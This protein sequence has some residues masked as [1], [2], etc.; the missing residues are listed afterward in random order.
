MHFGW[1]G[2]LLLALGPGAGDGPDADAAVARAREALRARLGIADSRINLVDASAAR[3]NDT[4]LGCPEKGQVYQPVLTQGHVVHLRVDDRT[5]DLRVTG[6]R[7][8]VCE[9]A[10]GAAAQAVA[11]ARVS[12]LARR[13]LA[14]R[15]K[16]SESDVHVEFVRPR[17]W[18]DA[19]LGCGAEGSLAAPADDGVRGFLIELTAGGQRHEY[20]ADTDRVVACG[21]GT[22]RAPKP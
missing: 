3:W 9:A 4:S 1:L 2:A 22:T 6:E 10:D 14:A 17:T 16:L 20:H 12:R 7:A 15:L 5:Y 8:R 11:A 18:P 19:S 13:D 21:G